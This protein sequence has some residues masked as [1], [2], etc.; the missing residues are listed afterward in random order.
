MTIEL[1]A[2][3]RLIDDQH[4]SIALE[5]DQLPGITVS[6]LHERY[7]GDAH[8]YDFTGHV[9]QSLNVVAGESLTMI[10]R[11][12]GRIIASLVNEVDCR[13]DSRLLLHPKG[14]YNLLVYQDRLEELTPPTYL[15]PRSVKVHE[16]QFLTTTPQ[17]PATAR[18]A[19]LLA[20]TRAYYAGRNQPLPEVMRQ[21]LPVLTEAIEANEEAHSRKML[22][23][24]CMALEGLAISISSL[25]HLQASDA[26]AVTRP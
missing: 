23:C 15:P 16:V 22:A 1:T 10:A 25:E 5:S 18:L 20:A 19:N 17:T 21:L 14:G 13:E 9:Q 12:Q 26:M 3:Y 24:L 2:A 4:A 6:I 7:A 11:C 8:T